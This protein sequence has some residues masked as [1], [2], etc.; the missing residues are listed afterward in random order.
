MPANPV[1]SPA[2]VLPVYRAA[3]KVELSPWAVVKR[4]EP[5]RR[6]DT[7]AKKY[8]GHERQKDFPKH[9]TSSTHWANRTPRGPSSEHAN[10]PA[11]RTITSHQGR[12]DLTGMYVF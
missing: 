7:S 11:A 4:V 10:G 6:S 2:D 1:V 3:N 12:A 8:Q 9:R 5:V